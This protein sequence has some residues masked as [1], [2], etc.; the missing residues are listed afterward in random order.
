MIHAAKVAKVGRSYPRA[1][2][3]QRAPVRRLSRRSKITGALIAG[4][5]ALGLIGWLLR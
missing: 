4:I 5:S 1:V 2:A 3:P